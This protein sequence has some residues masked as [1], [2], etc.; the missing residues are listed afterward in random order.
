MNPPPPPATV[1]AL[2]TGSSSI[3]FAFYRDETP[4]RRTLHGTVD[5]I[6]AMGTRLTFANPSDQDPDTRCREVP[7]DRSAATFLMQ[8]LEAQ[9]EF[10][11]VAAVGHRVV[12]GMQ[13]HEP[14]EV[15]PELLAEL[16]E[17]SANAPGHLPREIELME[18]FQH[19]YPRLPQVACFDTMFHRGMPRVARL[20]PLPRRYEA[21]GVRRYGFHGLSFGFLMEELGRL[22]DRAAHSGRV[23]LA[24]LGNGASL[25]A[26]QDGRC[27]DTTMG[28]TPNSGLVMGTRT[29]DLDPGVAPFLARTEGLS[30]E[31]FEEMINHES[32]LLGVSEISSDMRDLLVREADDERSADAVALFCYQARK[33]IGA[34]AA[35]LGG[36][37]TLVFS[38]GI[39]E[40]SSRI[41]TRICENLGF[42]GLQL[43]ETRNQAAASVISSDSSRVTVRVLHT[44][45]AW[46]IARWVLQT[47]SAAARSTTS[48][49]GLTATPTA[50]KPLRGLIPARFVDIL[51]G[52]L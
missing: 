28:F 29:G 33:S 23:I 46:M 13:R 9:D 14:A 35:A 51:D 5:R 34:L 45:E 6:G 27:L 41:R 7:G 4:L 20:L 44:D 38:G 18:A 43:S 1:L 15:T 11:S 48:G 22:E 26:V 2:N 21:K 49:A 47:R 36:L 31:R 8:W 10:A 3:K 42:L 39:G 52:N 37:E 40:N 12:H 17:T 24:H 25:A 50:P 30:P 19:R 16:R 32:G